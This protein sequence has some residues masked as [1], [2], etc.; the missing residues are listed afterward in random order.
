MR[1]AFVRTLTEIAASDSRAML[2]TADLGYKLFDELSAQCPGR[3]LNMGVSEANMVS[4]AAGLAL[5]GKRPV[6]Y[7]IVPFA[8]IR[9]L[10]QIRNDVC[11]MNAPVIVVGVGG[12]FAY[13]VNGPSHHGIDDVAALRA[14]PG[15]TIV[16][17]CDPPET[18]Q[19]LH[20]LFDLGAPAYLRLGRAGEMVLPGTDADFSLGKPTVLR[21]GETVALVAVGP[22][23]REA[24]RA[25]DLLGSHGVDP[26]VLSAHTVKPL[27]STAEG[28]R[29]RSVE[30]VFVVEEHG[31]CGGMFEALATEL[32]SQS[33]RPVV[34]GI[35]GPDRFLERVGSQS[36]I[37]EAVGLT[38]E[39]I[40]DTVLR[41][42]ER[43]A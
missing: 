33:P 1:D 37:W 38:G 15:M 39:A 20:A 35:T 4:V 31:P 10:E 34:V 7:S 3:F 40:C 16:C 19:A 23:A 30:Y 28:I 26:L 32:A 9:C 42:L 36:S 43:R 13:G 6:T 27:G 8:T 25:A 11:G 24:L 14:L 5:S 17:P 18:S 2:L 41:A 29:R 21:N 22:V 12:G